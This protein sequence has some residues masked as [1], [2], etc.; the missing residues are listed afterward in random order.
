MENSHE[1]ESNPPTGVNRPNQT[2]V[3]G[4]P[5]GSIAKLA[6]MGCFGPFQHERDL[7]T[8]VGPSFLVE[9]VNDHSLEPLYDTGGIV[10]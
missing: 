4:R 5:F 1:N 6:S 10:R 3:D 2:S 9:L 8:P 7:A